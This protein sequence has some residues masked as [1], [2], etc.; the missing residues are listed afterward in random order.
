MLGDKKTQNKIAQSL[1][2]T[3]IHDADTTDKVGMKTFAS[4]WWITGYLGPYWGHYYFEPSMLEWILGLLEV[5]FHS[6][7]Y[8]LD[9][10]CPVL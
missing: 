3:L 10:K 2:V 5:N 4:H 8:G 1:Y 9:Q 7:C 6:D